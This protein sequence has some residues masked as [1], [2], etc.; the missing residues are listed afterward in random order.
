MSVELLAAETGGSQRF[1]PFRLSGI[2]SANPD[3]MRQ[4]I[5]ETFA[6]SAGQTLTLSVR[7]TDSYGLI[8]QV[9]LD[10]FTL[11][12]NSE[13]TH[14]EWTDSVTIMKEFGEVMFES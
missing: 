10:R 1:E 2:I 7:A 4:A 5:N 13:P 6:V 12:A 8:Y 11:D 3:G 14:A 9:V